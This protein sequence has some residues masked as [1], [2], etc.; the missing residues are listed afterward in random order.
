MSTTLSWD[1]HAFMLLLVLLP[2]WLI[3]MGGA[4]VVFG[5]TEIVFYIASTL[6]FGLVLI[7]G[8]RPPTL[9]VGRVITYVGISVF[10]LLSLTFIGMLFVFLA[11]YM[12]LD[13]LGTLI[14]HATTVPAAAITIGIVMAGICVGALLLLIKN[15]G[16]AVNWSLIL[17]MIS[18]LFSLAVLTVLFLTAVWRIIESIVWL[19]L[20]PLGVKPMTWQVVSLLL[21]V[22][23]S[24]TIIYQL[25]CNI[26][27]VNPIDWYEDVTTGSAEEYPTLHAMTTSVATQL[28]IPV[29]TLA[30]SERAEPEAIAVGYQQDHMALILSRGTLEI[31]SEDELEAVI[32]HELAHVANMDAMVTTVA[33]LPA[34]L[35]DD[36]QDRF[37]NRVGDIASI[38]ETLSAFVVLYSYPFWVITLFTAYLTRPVVAVLSRARESVA[39]RTAATV[40]GSPAALISALQSLDEGIAETPDEDLRETSTRSSLSILPLAPFETDPQIDPDSLL[41]PLAPDWWWSAAGLLFATHP[42]TDHR[43]DALTAL[44]EDHRR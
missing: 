26:G 15:T 27:R 31:L 3:F 39:D 11:R 9:S 18:A 30:I 2:I 12:I 41:S 17:R 33:S 14:D 35:A 43:I 1:D 22:G 16:A 24:S 37:F 29:P 42:P 23:M 19:G 10:F 13:P 8:T 38:S 5:S 4:T 36:L 6:T 25:Y 7:A 44:L 34:L 20:S 32:A 40:T 21:M 28:D